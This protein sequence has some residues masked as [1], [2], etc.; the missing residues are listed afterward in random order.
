MS[1]CVGIDFASENLVVSIA[2]IAN[3]Y[4]PHP[5]RNELSNDSTPCLLGFQRNQFVIG[6][7]AQSINLSCPTNV[8]KSLPFFLTKDYEKFKEIKEK[9]SDIFN[10]VVDNDDNSLVFSI[11]DDNLTNSIPIEVAAALLL[12]K[13]IDIARNSSYAINDQVIIAVPSSYGEREIQILQ[14]A[15]KLAKI[16]NLSFAYSGRS[17]GY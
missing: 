12:E 5:L 3:P 16:Q 15:G 10:E 11:K 6:E 7:N 2:D 8:I 4:V 9:E 13:C 17:V 1:Y 14:K